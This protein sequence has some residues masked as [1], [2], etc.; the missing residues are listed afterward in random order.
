MRSDVTNG[1]VL[2]RHPDNPLYVTDNT[3]R[4]IYLS[5]SHTWATIQERRL[6]QQ[7]PF[8]YDDYLD[9]MVAHGHNFLRVWTWEHATWMQFTEEPIQYPPFRY[10]RT[11]PGT[12]LDG[13]PKFD[14]DT[15]ND[16]FFSRLRERVVK[17]GRRGIYVSVMFFQKFSLN[18][19]WGKK[20]GGNAWRG[21]PFNEENNVNGIDGDL[22]KTNTG[23][24]MHTLR[25]PAI[26]RHQE[27]FV[28]K[29]IDTLG[30]LDHILWEIGNECSESS[31]SWQYHLI[32]V[33]QEYEKSKP[34]QHLVG[35]TGMPLCSPSLFNSS[36]DWISPKEVEYLDNPPFNNGAKIVITDTDHS[37]PENHAPAYV[38]RNFFRGNHFILMELYRDFRYGL[39]DDV[40]HSWDITRTAMGTVVTFSQ[41]IE[42]ARLRPYPDLADSGYCLAEPGRE[43]Y[44]YQ[45]N[46]GDTPVDLRHALGACSAEWIDCSTLE[47]IAAPCCEGGKRQQ[48]HSPMQGPFVLHVCTQGES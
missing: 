38:W 11:G 35:M 16:A 47:R 41:Q 5:G 30:D 3:N 34:K 19:L 27:R 33:V 46:L 45:E 2:R 8:D 36:A 44:V 32:R 40:D 25:N 1:G 4:V 6:P 10:M 37:K 14:L 9:F 31:T 12:A 28:K 15:F 17:A 22:D 20:K 13:E 48:F 24:G 39:K 29:V 42:L 26:V 7:A 18:C 23:N 43:Y 21:H